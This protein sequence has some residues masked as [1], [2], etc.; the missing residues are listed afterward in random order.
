MRRPW[1]WC[2]GLLL[3]LTALAAV[4]TPPQ[5]P[6]A[7][8]GAPDNF[9]QLV[10]P[11]IQEKLDLSAAQKEKLAKLQQEFREKSNEVRNRTQ[12]EVDKIR[13]TAGKEG[14]KLDRAAQ[15]QLNEQ[16]VEML[17]SYQKLRGEYDPQLRA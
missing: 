5:K 6:A 8:A 16:F 12:E 13:S 4:Q 3:G 1:T 17:K 7:P 14:K 10:P 15:R 2:L 9:G 11:A